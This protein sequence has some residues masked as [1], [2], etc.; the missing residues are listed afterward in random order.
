[1]LG[2]YAVEVTARS[3]SEEHRKW[4]QDLLLEL[5]SIDN[6]PKAD[7]DLMRR[8]EG[9]VFEII[10]REVGS[11]CSYLRPQVHRVPIDVGLIS[12]HQYV[13]PPH[14][15]KTSDR[16]NGLPMEEAYAG[17]G[18]LVVVLDGIEGRKGDGP[19]MCSH[20]DTVAPYLTNVRTEDGIVHGRGAC[21]DKGSIVS[22]IE[23]MRLMSELGEKIGSNP[24][25]RSVVSHFVIDEEPGGNG[26]LSLSLSEKWTSDN[27]LV[28]EVTDLVPHRANRGALWY[29][30]DLNGTGSGVNSLIALAHIV[31]SLEAEGERILEETPEGI[32]LKEHVQTSHGII[33]APSAGDGP[34]V[35]FGQHPSTVN[36]YVKLA[37]CTEVDPKNLREDI[38]G[39]IRE[40]VAKYGDKTLEI[41]PETGLPKVARHFNMVGRDA[42]GGMAYDVEIFGKT[43]HMGAIRQ[44][45]CAIIK[46]AY[47]LVGLQ[48]LAKEKE[49]TMDT[50]LAGAEDL[51]NRRLVL[52]GGQGFTASHDLAEIQSRITS[53]VDKGI[54]SYLSKTRLTATLINEETSF[55]KLHND[56]YESPEGSA[57]WRTVLDTCRLTGIRLSGQERGAWRVSCDARLYAKAPKVLDPSKGFRNVITFGAGSLKF[58]H[59]E[60]ERV[61]VSDVLLAGS[62]IAL[63]A[64]K[65]S[66]G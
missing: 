7:V 20:V 64:M 53:A 40:Y 4:A 57:A 37:T 21:D 28:T 27:I 9:E 16:P 58:A 1:M 6:T 65:L 33:A 32:F 41:D 19:T 63:W 24:L 43:G 11:L 48:R 12:G 66:R 23:A 3:R 30:V 29:R 14:Y 31:L 49:A 62:T 2:E 55:D 35:A 25:G 60:A 42:G 36:G 38:E 8:N 5:V 51:P 15:T 44:C 50:F 59:S 22:I 46:M 45:D 56:A 17:R 10:E 26:A 54:G 61:S 39:S 13:T 52:E 47:V 18:N 34:G